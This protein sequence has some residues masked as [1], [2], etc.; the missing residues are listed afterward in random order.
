MN[1]KELR[2]REELRKAEEEAWE[3]DQFDILR[4]Y[5]EEQRERERA[6]DGAP[7]CYPQWGISRSSEPDW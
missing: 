1:M 6:F 5:V 3:E 4:Q 7:E 2:K